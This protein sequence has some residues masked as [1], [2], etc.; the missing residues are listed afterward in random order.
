MEEV[1]KYVKYTADFTH[2]PFKIR[3]REVMNSPLSLKKRHETLQI[4]ITQRTFPVCLCASSLT[5]LALIMV[6]SVG[7][8]LGGQ[9]I[10]LVACLTGGT[11]HTYCCV[12]RLVCSYSNTSCPDQSSAADLMVTTKDGSRSG[13]MAGGGIPAHCSTTR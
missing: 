9:S 8:M 1:W 2:V 5:A 11:I 10:K 13:V 3:L 7:E 6:M 12:G 4:P